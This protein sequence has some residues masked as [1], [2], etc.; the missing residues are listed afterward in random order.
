MRSISELAAGHGLK[1]V[2]A[3]GNNP[4]QVCRASSVILDTDLDKYQEQ[5]Q[6]ERGT[7]L[8][9]E[10]RV[11]QGLRC[12]VMVALLTAATLVSGNV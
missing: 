2:Q 4:W 8:A 5:R 11:L 10:K 6:E 12:A 3:D 1:T 7:T 9:S